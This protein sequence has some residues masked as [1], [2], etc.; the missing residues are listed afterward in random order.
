MDWTTFVSA[1]GTP[2][3]IVVAAWITIHGQNVIHKKVDAVHDEVTTA[4]GQTIAMLAD[5]AED[6]RII[7]NGGAPPQH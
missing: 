7:G 2:V 1:I 4:N 6:R 3:A 5:A